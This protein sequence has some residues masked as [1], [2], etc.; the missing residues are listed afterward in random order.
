MTE[1]RP[2]LGPQMDTPVTQLRINQFLLRKR[3]ESRSKADADFNTFGLGLIISRESSGR[4][5]APLFIE[6]IA[7]AAHLREGDKAP[8]W[9]NA[10]GAMKGLKVVYQARSATKN[11]AEQAQPETRVVTE[12]DLEQWASLFMNYT[13][14]GIIQEA[15]AALIESGDKAAAEIFHEDVRLAFAW[16][17]HTALVDVQLRPG[18]Q[19]VPAA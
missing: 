3:R 4:V 14:F 9:L 10:E 8:S 12:Q 13:T 19:V 6:F 17:A 18:S 15:R 5:Y 1:R 11:S 2:V 16:L 7:E